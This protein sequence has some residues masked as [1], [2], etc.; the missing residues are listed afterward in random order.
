MIGV[1]EGDYGAD[2]SRQFRGVSP[3]LAEGSLQ[4]L[5]S[6]LSLEPV[7]DAAVAALAAA[8]EG[9]AAAP[10]GLLLALGDATVEC[11]RPRT[12]KW[13]ASGDFIR[14]FG[15]LLVVVAQ[16]DGEKAEY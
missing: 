9:H 16:S 3:Q 15:G 4:R 6:G 5:H 13:M 2:A 12:R 7:A 10:S 11:Q 14:R 1:F 8:A